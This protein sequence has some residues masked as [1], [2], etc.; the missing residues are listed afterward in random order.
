M[1]RPHQAPLQ[2]DRGVAECAARFRPRCANRRRQA[3]RFSDGPHPLAT[4]ARDRF[5]QN[6]VT[7]RR[8]RFRNHLVGHVDAEWLLG[9]GNDGHAGPFCRRTRRRLATHRGNRVS[10]RTDEDQAGIADRCGKILVLGQKAVARMDGIGP[11]PPRRINDRINPQVAF[12]RRARPD[13][14]RFVGEAD[15]KGG[16]IAV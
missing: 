14:V 13:R 10:R 1:A 3:R 16:T 5:D 11:G 9:A 4:T 7:D 6:R 8:R 2:V 15:M 12:A